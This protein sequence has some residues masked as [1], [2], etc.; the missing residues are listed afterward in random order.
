MSKYWNVK[1]YFE[2]TFV[3]L[4][5]CWPIKLRIY[6]GFMMTNRWDQWKWE[7]RV[8]LLC[9][10]A[11]AIITGH[12]L[13]SK[14]EDRVCLLCVCVRPARC[15][16]TFAICSIYIYIYWLELLMLFKNMA[17]IPP[18]VSIALFLFSIKISLIFQS[19]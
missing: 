3:C 5:A 10:E 17:V 13:V 14:W 9:E 16:Y 11:D 8:C 2:A 18:I 1:V 15:C 4:I 6:I 12:E 7:D 19:L